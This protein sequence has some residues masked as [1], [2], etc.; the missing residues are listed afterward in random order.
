[1]VS[2]QSIVASGMGDMTGPSYSKQSNHNF[3][4]PQIVKQPVLKE[5]DEAALNDMLHHVGVQNASPPKVQKSNENFNEPAS[6]NR[7]LIL[8]GQPQQELTP[9]QML[10]TG[11]LSEDTNEIIRR[12]ATDGYIAA[13]SPARHDGGAKTQQDALN[14]SQ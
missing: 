6:S 4:N 5:H 3:N 7:K 11:T 1:M 2:S 9:S 10:R 14:S 13:A 8:A 12:Y